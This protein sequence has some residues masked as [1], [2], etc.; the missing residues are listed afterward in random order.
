MKKLHDV[1]HGAKWIMFHGLP[2]V[3]LGPSKRGGS[4][5]KLGAWQTMKCSLASRNITLP[6]WILD[7]LVSWD[8]P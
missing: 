7:Y 8:F 1:L 4:S 6:W 5:A 3:A 2:N